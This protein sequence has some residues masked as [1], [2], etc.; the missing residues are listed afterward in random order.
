VVVHSDRFNEIYQ[1]QIREYSREGQAKLRTYTSSITTLMAE[2]T[3]EEVEECQELAEVWNSH[4]SP[5]SVSFL[6]IISAIYY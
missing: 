6:D 4:C 3:A 1:Q 5:F 2:L